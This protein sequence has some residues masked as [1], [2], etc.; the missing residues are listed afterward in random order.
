MLKRL[1]IGLGTSIT[2]LA[3]LG[4][5][6]SLEALCLDSTTRV[7]DYSPLGGLEALRA[8][9]IGVSPQSHAVIRMDSDAFL[10]RLKRLELL[11]LMDVRVAERSFLFEGNMAGL[12][13]AFFRL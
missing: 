3:P 9:D 6:G 12:K 5:L 4:E 10:F 8:L 11:H 7:T 2:D 1:W 13:Y